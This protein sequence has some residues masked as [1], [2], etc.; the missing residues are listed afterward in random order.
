MAKVSLA[1]LVSFGRELPCEFAEDWRGR[2]IAPEVNHKGF[3]YGYWANPLQKKEC[4]LRCVA[5]RV[6][7]ILLASNEWPS[8]R[9]AVKRSNEAIA[10]STHPAEM[11]IGEQV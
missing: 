3:L 5:A 7:S 6:I 8:S 2:V 11:H 10:R 1:I 4:P 9:L